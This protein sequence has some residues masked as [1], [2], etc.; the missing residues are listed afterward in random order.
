VG[1]VGVWEGSVW[2]WKLRWRRDRFEWEV[3]LETDLRIHI[4]RD[5]VMK[6]EKDR[7]VWKRDESGRFTVRSA[8]E[9]IE[10]IG[11]VMTFYG[12][13]TAFVRSNNCP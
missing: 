10:E 2:C 4:S 3:P 9:C 1:E 5:S 6:D 7:Q 8:Y 12:K 11:R 13:C